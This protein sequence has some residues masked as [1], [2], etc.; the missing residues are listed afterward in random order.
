MNRIISAISFAADKHRNQRR[1]DIEASPY[2]NHPIALANVLAGEAGIEDERV[3]IAAILHETVSSAR[4]T[5]TGRNWW[6]WLDR[7][8]L[9]K[10]W[11]L[12]G[13]LL[14]FSAVLFIVFQISALV[15]A[16]TSARLAEWVTPGQRLR[17]QLDR[18]LRLQARRLDMN[19]H[20]RHRDLRLLLARQR[21]Q[22]HEAERQREQHR[23]QDAED[24]RRTLRARHPR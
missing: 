18:I 16:A 21:D 1:K 20:H 9:H 4:T 15:D 10:R 5:D 6:Y 12:V 17:H 3:L 7:L 2:I 23:E 11:G 13:S 14:V 19:I 24:P 22:R 8:F